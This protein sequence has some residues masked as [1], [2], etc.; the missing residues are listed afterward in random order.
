MCV[1]R[2][3][4]VPAPTPVI[5]RQAYKNAPSRDSLASDDPDARRRKLAGVETSAQ[6]VTE[7]AS[8]TRRTKA[9]G[10]QTLMPTLGGAGSA[11]IVAASLASARSPM[12][13][14]QTGVGAQPAP[15]PADAGGIAG[16][17]PLGGGFLAMAIAAKKKKAA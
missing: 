5:E 9:G 15:A 11:P 13:A 1:A 7:A 17:A 6:G 12:R 8:T 10:D 16:A 4:R 2:R 14:P 3:P